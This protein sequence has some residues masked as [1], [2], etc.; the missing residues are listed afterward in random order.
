MEK[1]SSAIAVKYPSYRDEKL[2]SCKRWMDGKRVDDGA[3]GLW[4]VHDKLYDLTDFIQRHPG[5]SMWLEM[6]KGVDITEQFESQHITDL[7]EKTLAK[8]F[9]RNAEQPRNYK[10]TFNENGFYKTLKRKVAAKVKNLDQSEVYKSRLY[11]DLLLAA[12]FA[13]SILAAAKNN[14]LFAL[15]ASICLSCLVIASHNFLHQRNNWRMYLTNIAMMSFRDWRVFHAMSHHPYPNSLHDLEVSAFEPTLRWLPETKTT[16][17]ILQSW[18]ISPLSYL[19]TFFNSYYLRFVYFKANLPIVL[20]QLFCLLKPV[21]YCQYSTF[22]ARFCK[23][24]LSQIDLSSVRSFVR[25]LS[26]PFDGVIFCSLFG[27]PKNHKF[28]T[29]ILRFV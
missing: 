28:N 22:L 15:I 9:V 20:A 23:K 4:R 2:K 3:K 10:I 16:N 11:C 6:T 19:L 26:R 27:V 1:I 5:G 8:F 24:P 21:Q 12:T 25:S 13:L 14:H 17:Q 18:L 29:S 7:A